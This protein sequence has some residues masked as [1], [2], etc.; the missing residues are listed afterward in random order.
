MSEITR[1]S[2]R[3]F[4]IGSGAAIAALVTPIKIFDE[5]A[6]AI[7]RPRFRKV[8]DVLISSNIAADGTS[9][10]S[11]LRDNTHLFQ[12]A[13]NWR[14]CM[15]WIAVPGGELVFPDDKAMHF[16]VSPAFETTRLCVHYEDREGRKFAET[17]KWF[18]NV[19]ILADWAPLDALPVEPDDSLEDV[20]GYVG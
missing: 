2:R 12:I 18:N 9:E 14:A 19:P 13:L 7:T 4:L 11:M 17:Y 20:E 8:Y 10:F 5:V 16:V 3:N 15:R 6:K 1:V